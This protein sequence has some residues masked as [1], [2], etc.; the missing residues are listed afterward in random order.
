MIGFL[1]LM[2]FSLILK[3]NSHDRI[4]NER[5]GNAV[6]GSIIWGRLNSF[7]SSLSQNFKVFKSVELLNNQL[8][9][10]LVRRQMYNYS[11]LGYF[12]W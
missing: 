2:F 3:G 12:Y 7:N 1:L 9:K 4:I 8:P 11:A 5:S 6:A 10:T